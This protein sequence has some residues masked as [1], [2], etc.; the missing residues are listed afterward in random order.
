MWRHWGEL[1]VGSVGVQAAPE[2]G[3]VQGEGPQETRSPT[4]RPTGGPVQ[5]N[6]RGTC[7]QN[8]ADGR[9]CWGQ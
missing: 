5:L 6:N 3:V 8:V 4:V 9:Q 7:E 1:C 2:Q